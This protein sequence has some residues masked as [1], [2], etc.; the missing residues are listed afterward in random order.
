MLILFEPITYLMPAADAA[1]HLNQPLGERLPVRALVL[2]Q[3][4][5][6]YYTIAGRFT[7][8]FEQVLLIADRDNQV[9][10]VALISE[11]PGDPPR[12]AAPAFNPR[13]R[14]YDLVR[15]KMDET[16]GMRIGCDAQRV[17]DRLV[18]IDTELLPRGG[19]DGLKTA[20]RARLLLHQRIVN[21]ILLRLQGG[22]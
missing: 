2:P 8:G 14:A 21:L 12:L 18:R 17:T 3:N 6:F 11:N 5:L 19:P 22:G 13:W 10:G 7:G 16:G 9:V 20:Y 15:W 1:G 4:S